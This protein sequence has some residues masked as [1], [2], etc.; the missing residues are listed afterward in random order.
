MLKQSLNERMQLKDLAERVRNWRSGMS[1]LT[2]H[3]P[4]QYEI[5]RIEFLDDVGN[6]V[7]A[8]CSYEDLL[9]ELPRLKIWRR[10][11]SSYDN[12]EY[13]GA[14]EDRL[15]VAFKD[16]T[17]TSK[18]RVVCGEQSDTLARVVEDIS[19]LDFYSWEKYRLN[20]CKGELC[21][22]LGYTHVERRHEIVRENV[23]CF[24]SYSELNALFIPTQIEIDR[25]MKDVDETT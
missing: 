17:V 3:S 13:V 21:I 10:I 8:I 18:I 12:Y 4:E 7:I 11:Y 14:E 19:F 23:F 2:F 15:Y 1:F 25:L 16:M 20:C 9:K 6:V 24:E 22:G 5:T